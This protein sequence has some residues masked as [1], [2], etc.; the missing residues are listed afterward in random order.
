MCWPWS[1]PYLWGV[2]AEI[3]PRICLHNESAE[4]QLKKPSNARTVGC[5]MVPTDELVGWASACGADL[6]APAPVAYRRLS[7][8]DTL[9][10]V[11]ESCGVRTPASTVLERREVSTVDRLLLEANGPVVVQQLTD[12]HSGKGTRLVGSVDDFVEAASEMGDETYKL[13]LYVPGLP[14][15]VSGY[16]SSLG[17]GVT[18]VSHQLVS[19]QQDR[20]GQHFGNQILGEL[21][22][23]SGGMSRLRG[24][25]ALVGEALRSEDFCG[26]FGIDAVLEPSG[27][28]VVIEINPRI[29]STTA[30]GAWQEWDSG[31]LPGPLLHVLTQ[32][33]PTVRFEET[34]LRASTLSQCF[35]RASCSFEARWVMVDGHYA[36]ADGDLSFISDRPSSFA[37]SPRD[38]RDVW[39][40]SAVTEI[41]QKV[42]AGGLVAIVHSHGR[43]HSISPT[44][45]WTP[46]GEVVRAGVMRFLGISPDN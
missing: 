26:T 38:G 35:V 42:E 40:W 17:V 6:L 16:V 7:G 45:A 28:A 25:A 5:V 29:Q 23:G 30:L 14:C 46:H 9:D 15:T 2:A 8:K 34:T 36:I 39:I 32:V 20:F 33:D 4:H 31:L 41:G 13:S 12:G 18:T 43:L 24:A 1:S 44:P 3:F 11:L 10:G 27:D 22:V 37:A 21:D 19:S